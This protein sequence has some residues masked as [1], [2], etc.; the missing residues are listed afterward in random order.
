[1]QN[2]APTPLRVWLRSAPGPS[3]TLV[4]VVTKKSSGAAAATAIERVAA[5][6]SSLFIIQLLISLRPNWL[7]MS[8][9]ILTLFE[10]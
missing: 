3:S 2:P 10:Q 9:F 8:S 7:V 1:M 5:L 6:S 4:P